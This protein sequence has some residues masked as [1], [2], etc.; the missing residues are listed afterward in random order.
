M[1][2]MEQTSIQPGKDPQLWEIARLRAGFNSHV[3]TYLVVNTF[4][5]FVWYFTGPDTGRFHTPWPLYPA[6]G[7][8]VGLI[9]HYLRAYVFPGHNRVEKEYEK[10]VKEN[11]RF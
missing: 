7:W 6:L 10:L 4:L 8:G 9:F 1:I 3:M 2:I 11:N 5:W